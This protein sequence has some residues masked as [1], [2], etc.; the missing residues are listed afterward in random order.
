MHYEIETLTLSF[1][2]QFR[3][4][5]APLPRK[6]PAVPSL[7]RPESS[8]KTRSKSNDSRGLSKFV[9]GSRLRLP[10]RRQLLSQTSP[11]LPSF[12]TSDARVVRSLG[13]WTIPRLLRIGQT[14]F[15]WTRGVSVLT[16]PW[17]SLSYRLPVSTDRSSQEL[18]G[19]R[20]QSSSTNRRCS[21]SA[22][23]VTCEVQR[24]VFA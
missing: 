6:L 11:I 23:E 5:R 17:R 18:Q 1:E 9:G 21:M 8:G 13:G 14:V 19:V 10:L 22:G 3:G 20:D 4:R 7:Q 16:L 15:G 24:E 2:G 12:Q